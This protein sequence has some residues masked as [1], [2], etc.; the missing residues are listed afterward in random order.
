MIDYSD[1]R[2]LSRSNPHS[3][4]T[5]TRIFAASTLLALSICMPAIVVALL[6]YYVVKMSLTLTLITSTI[7][8]F[9]AMG[10]GYKLSKKIVKIQ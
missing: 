4:V 7:T 9:L 6:M 10:L 1:E 5:M 3:K 8:L 2:D